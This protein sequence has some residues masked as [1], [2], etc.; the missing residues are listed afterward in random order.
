MIRKLKSLW[1][2]YIIYRGVELTPKGKCFKEYCEKIVSNNLDNTIESYE[3]FIYNIQEI[4]IKDHR[5]F[6][7]RIEAAEFILKSYEEIL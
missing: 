2:K 5:L 3:D 1:N 7:D 4:L 6:L